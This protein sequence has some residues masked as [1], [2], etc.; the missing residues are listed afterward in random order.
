MTGILPVVELL[1]GCKSDAE[2][3][4]W[5]LT[6]PLAVLYRDQADIRD[7]LRRAKFSHGERLLDMEVAAM[8]SVRSRRGQ[9]PPALEQ[10]LDVTR[11]AVMTY[12]PMDGAA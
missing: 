10:M 7:A 6:V 8:S 11:H 5:L 4:R 1:V 9:M 3:A 12:M 2:R